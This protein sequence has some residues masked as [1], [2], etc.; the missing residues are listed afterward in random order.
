MLCWSIVYHPLSYRISHKCANAGK[1]KFCITKLLK[2]LV[3]SFVRTFIE[4]SI[5]FKCCNSN[6][7]HLSNTVVLLLF[8]IIPTSDMNDQFCLHILYATHN[9]NWISHTYMCVLI[10]STN[11]LLI[12]SKTNNNYDELN[13]IWL[14]VLCNLGTNSLSHIDMDEK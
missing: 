12:T 7:Y 5:L 6:W 3:F 4:Y 8:I 9:S 13:F 11:Y 10:S 14:I 2:V 1:F